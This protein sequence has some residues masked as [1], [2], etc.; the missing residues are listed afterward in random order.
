MKD[1]SMKKSILAIAMASALVACAAPALA[2]RDR[3]PGGVAGGLIGCCFGMRTAAAWN[4]GKGIG[5]RD[6]LDLIVIGRIWSAI[7]GWGGTTT[8]QLHAESPAYY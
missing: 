4:D 2:D 7:E 5:I 8:S 3:Q 6:I 1:S